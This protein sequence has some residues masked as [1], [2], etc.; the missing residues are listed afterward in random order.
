MHTKNYWLIR[1]KKKLRT[2]RFSSHLHAF[3]ALQ[4]RCPFPLRMV[5]R[6]LVTGWGR[7]RRRGQGGGRPPRAPGGRRPRRRR[8]PRWGGRGGGGPLQRQLSRVSGLIWL[9]LQAPWDLLWFS[10][11]SIG[12][13]ILAGDLGNFVVDWRMWWFLAGGL[14]RDLGC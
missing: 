7:C 8:R 4:H 1:T 11:V 9:R 6:S 13:Q 14:V 10:G 3:L 5:W 2:V 12:C